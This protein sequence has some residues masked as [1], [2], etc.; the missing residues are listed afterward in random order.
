LWEQ[1]TDRKRKLIAKNPKT[2]FADLCDIGSDSIF[3]GIK[4]LKVWYRPVVK[5]L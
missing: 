2:L 1:A 3:K 5:K 4:A